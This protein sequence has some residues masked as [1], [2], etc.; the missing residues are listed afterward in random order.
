MFEIIQ[1]QERLPLAQIENVEK[2]LGPLKRLGVKCW[3][4]IGGARR[5]I[6]QADL[7]Q[8]VLLAVG[9]E[10]RGLSGAMRALCDGFIRIPMRA[11][12]SSLSLSQ[13]ACILAAEAMRQRL[14]A[15][16]QNTG[17]AP[18]AIHA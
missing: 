12:A 17:P 7:T 16:P 4:C 14:F 11:G 2:A 3:G 13:A 15:Q 1:H 18:D 10:R 6:F 5:D 8:A 9:G